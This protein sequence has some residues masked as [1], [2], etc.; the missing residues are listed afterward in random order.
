MLDVNNYT[1]PWPWLKTNELLTTDTVEYLNGLAAAKIQD[2]RFYQ[3]RFRQELTN[4]PM[5]EQYHSSLKDAVPLFHKLLPTHR[6]AD[7]F[8]C[9]THLAVCAPWTFY[10]KHLDSS[11]K[12]FSIVSYIGEPNLGTQL[13][14]DNATVTVPWEQGSTVVFAPNDSTSWHSW[15]SRGSWRVTLI[16]FI[17]L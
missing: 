16:S 15:K 14:L 8:K 17:T 11:N 4:D 7:T 13:H 3:F 2:R 12:I 10:P 9:N 6:H 1:Y 5:L